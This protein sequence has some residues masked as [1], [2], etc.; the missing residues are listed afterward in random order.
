M[1]KKMIIIVCVCVA[2]AGSVWAGALTV[3][4]EDFS[5]S[6]VLSNKTTTVG[7]GTWNATSTFGADGSFTNTGTQGAA[8]LSFTPVLDKVYRLDVSF[9]GMSSG[10]DFYAAGFASSA[11]AEGLPPFKNTPAGNGYLA[12]APNGTVVAWGRKNQG[13]QNFATVD[14]GSGADVD[15]RIELN[16]VAETRTYD[17]T[18]YAK[19]ES[20]SDYTQIYSTNNWTPGGTI[21][22]VGFGI[23]EN[24]PPGVQ[25]SGRI[26]YF[27]LYEFVVMGT[28]VSVK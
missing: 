28:V 21:S 16:K 10:Y 13:G 14:I 7:S 5:G 9:R 15:L 26:T 17:M 1:T 8:I 4:R 27:H 24:S 19:E 20:D 2:L 22:R 18:W 6:G 12:V 11:P 25:T 23:D 3:Y